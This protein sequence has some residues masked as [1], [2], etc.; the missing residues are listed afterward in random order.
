ML[1]LKLSRWC[2]RTRIEELKNPPKAAEEKKGPAKVGLPMDDLRGTWMVTFSNHT[3]DQRKFHGRNQV[4]ISGADDGHLYRSRGEL[5]IE[6]PNKVIER[7][8]LGEE[9]LF[10]EHFNPGTTYPK[11]KVRV[12]GIAAKID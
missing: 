12:M 5:I 6:Y 9:R 8:T 3:R 10:F 1:I 11:G 2:R 7:I 4:T